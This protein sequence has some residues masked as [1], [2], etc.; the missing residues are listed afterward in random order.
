MTRQPVSAVKLRLYSGGAVVHHYYDN[1]TQQYRRKMLLH[2]EIIRHYIIHVPA[3][4]FKM[5]R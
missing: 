4:Y 1:R 2:K 5:V 3:K